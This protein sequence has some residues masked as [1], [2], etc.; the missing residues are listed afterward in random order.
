[1]AKTYKIFENGIEINRIVADEEFVVSY[2]QSKGYTYETYILEEPA[3]PETPTE[4]ETE[5]VTWDI[6]AA[7]YTEGV[8]SIDE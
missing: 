8:N 4:Q 6:L 5:P 7:A 2:C 1:M 3:E